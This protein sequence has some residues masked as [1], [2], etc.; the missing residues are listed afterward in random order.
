MDHLDDFNDH[1]PKKLKSSI[2][3]TDITIT[4]QANNQKHKLT[5]QTN[6]LSSFSLSHLQQNIPSK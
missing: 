3:T 4:D 2:Y 6:Y 5:A 1:Q